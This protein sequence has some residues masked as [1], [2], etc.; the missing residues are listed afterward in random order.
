MLLS[1]FASG[2]PA[3]KRLSRPAVGSA[4]ANSLPETGR[5]ADRAGTIEMAAHIGSAACEVRVALLAPRP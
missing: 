3:A 4:G 2:L 1:I 5:V